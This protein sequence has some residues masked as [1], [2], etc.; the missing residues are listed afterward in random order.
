MTGNTVDA[1]D[2]IQETILNVLESFNDKKIVSFKAYAY[3]VASNLYRL[4]KRRKK[5]SAEFKESELKGIIDKDQNPELF[6]D[7]EIIYDKILRLPAKTSEAIILFYVSDLSLEEIQKIQGGSLS[8]VKSRIKR[9]KEKLVKQFSSPEKF[10]L[11][12]TFL[13]L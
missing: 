6:T 7:F 2:L 10:M 5:F 11:A 9:G 4:K 13:S 12:I 1:E 8:G 3:A